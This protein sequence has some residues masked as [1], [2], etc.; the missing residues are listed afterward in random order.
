MGS[1]VPTDLYIA[2]CVPAWLDEAQNSVW[3]WADI[4]T[5]V[6]FK[7]FWYILPINVYH[8][9]QNH[10]KHTFFHEYME[11]KCDGILILFLDWFCT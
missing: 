6:I 1:A 8:A 10:G 11:I 4:W 3:I 9:K 5:K 2:L 7:N